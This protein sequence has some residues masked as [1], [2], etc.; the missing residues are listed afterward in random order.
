VSGLLLH[1]QQVGFCKEGVV[2]LTMLLAVQLLKQSSKVSF[3]THLT[4]KVAYET[5]G[6]EYCISQKCF[7]GKVS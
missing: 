7:V 6:T 2:S 1:D 3:K 5:N 4:L